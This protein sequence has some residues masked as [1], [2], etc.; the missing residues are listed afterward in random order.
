[1]M[2][3]LNSCGYYT[4]KN[5]PDP[6]AITE[7]SWTKMQAEFFGPRCDICH[8]QGGAG[9]N[10]SDYTD[11]KSKISRIQS[12]CLGTRKRMPPDSPLTAYESTLLLDWINKGAPLDR[13]SIP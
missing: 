4:E 13:V 7:V 12:E 1:M 8:G 2:V 3:A 11:V 9:I 6:S 5:P 10:T